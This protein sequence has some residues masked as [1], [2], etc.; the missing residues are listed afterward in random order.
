MPRHY[1]ETESE[2]SWW[3]IGAFV[4]LAVLFICLGLLSY[5]VWASNTGKNSGAV[6]GS[7]I[8]ASGSSNVS[9]SNNVCLWVVETTMAGD[10]GKV[11]YETFPKKRG[12][13]CSDMCVSEGT[14][15]GLA[16]MD[17]KPDGTKRSG[18]FCNAT[19]ITKC[20]GS[21]SVWTDCPALPLAAGWETQEFHFCY[22]GSCA[23]FVDVVWD[24][25]TVIPPTLFVPEST[26][27]NTYEFGPNAAVCSHILLDSIPDYPT[28]KDCLD[29]MYFSVQSGDYDHLCVFGY[30]CSRANFWGTSMSSITITSLNTLSVGTQ[31]LSVPSY[32]VQFF[33]GAKTPEEFRNASLNAMKYSR[34]NPSPVSGLSVKPTPSPSPKTPAPAHRKRTMATVQKVSKVEQKNH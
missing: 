19:D 4:G 15:S 10:T 27:D 29:S 14:C 18:P 12:T 32:A 2:H 20:R 1:K 23:Y 26:L 11:G 24:G 28:S 22:A 13:A 16:E 8:L 7:K 21:C 33:D 5:L 17:M 34:E 9:G 31:S 3:C 6:T 30:S 25:T